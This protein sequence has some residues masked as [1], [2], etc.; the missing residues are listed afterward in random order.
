MKLMTVLAAMVL[1]A[2][3]CKKDQTRVLQVKT[4]CQH[5]EV[6]YTSGGEQV[7]KDSWYD[8]TYELTADEGETVQVEMLWKSHPND[9][10]WNNNHTAPVSITYWDSIPSSFGGWIYANGTDFAE[11]LGGHPEDD[12]IS[13]SGVVPEL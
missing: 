3:A 11:G 7:V 4:Q 12:R 1:L 5:C 13:F 10:V 2:G 8:N 9:T 6:R